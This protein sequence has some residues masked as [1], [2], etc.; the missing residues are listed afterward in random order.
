MQPGCCYWRQGDVTS[1]YSPN[2]AEG[3]VIN[4]INSLITSQIADATVEGWDR[5]MGGWVGSAG[6]YHQ[7]LIIRCCFFQLDPGFMEPVCSACNWHSHRKHQRSQAALC[8]HAFF[9]FF[10]FF[11]FFFSGRGCWWQKMP[12]VNNTI[13]PAGQCY[14]QPVYSYSQPVCSICL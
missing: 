7:Q 14:S 4:Y 3:W 5:W 8:V 11:S 1:T 10:L 12:T 2:Q 9:S 13:G 6:K